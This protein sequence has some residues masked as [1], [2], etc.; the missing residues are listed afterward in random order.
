MSTET[1]T[2]ALD[3]DLTVRAATRIQ[4]TL[5]EALAKGRH[6]TLDCRDAERADLTFLQLVLTARASAE[7]AGGALRLVSPKGKAVAEAACRA[8]LA[9]PNCADGTGDDAF[10]LDHPNGE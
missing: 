2:I 10:W 3:G 7:A 8:G 6:V 1:A 4:S 5:T 9:G